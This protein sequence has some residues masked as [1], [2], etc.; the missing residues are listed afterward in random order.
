MSYMDF[1]NRSGRGFLM[2]KTTPRRVSQVQLL[3]GAKK[4]VTFVTGGPSAKRMT[5]MP[6]ETDTGSAST[7][8]TT[9]RPR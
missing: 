6:G 4:P 7:R 1:P 9:G 5:V 8:Q 2:H 3:H